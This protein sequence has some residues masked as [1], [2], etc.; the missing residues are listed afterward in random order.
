VGPGTAATMCCGGTACHAPSGAPPSTTA[1]PASKP[2]SMG[3][4]RFGAVQRGHR[5]SRC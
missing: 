2:I 1:S 3:K 4:G 5:R